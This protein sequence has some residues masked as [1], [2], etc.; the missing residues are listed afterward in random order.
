[1]RLL[2]AWI[3]CLSLSCNK[4]SRIFC[5]WQN[6]IAAAFFS[7]KI[8]NKAVIDS[9]L[10]YGTCY[11]N[12]LLKLNSDNLNY[13]FVFLFSLSILNAS[14][15]KLSLICWHSIEM[16]SIFAF[17]CK[18][19]KIIASEILL[20]NICLFAY[21]VICLKE[22]K[23]NYQIITS[24]RIFNLISFGFSQIHRKCPKV[25][26]ATHLLSLTHTKQ[27]KTTQTK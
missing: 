19:S 13:L 14:F 11:N 9:S 27:N 6:R 25:F 22:D 1:M 12:K 26:I 20:L 7:R 3:F 2:Y 10:Q 8:I 15:C 23:K 16:Q 24:H 17:G 18:T 21:S 4:R 5:Y